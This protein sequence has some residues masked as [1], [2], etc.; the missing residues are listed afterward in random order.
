MPC[1]GTHLIGIVSAVV[2]AVAEELVVDA[3][4]VG[5]VVGAAGAGRDDAHEG[6]ER[7]A[8]RQLPL[9]VVRGLSLK[10]GLK[11]GANAVAVGDVGLRHGPVTEVLRDLERK[12]L[13]D[14]KLGRG[15]NGIAEVR[16]YFI[17][18]SMIGLCHPCQ[19]K[20]NIMKYKPLCLNYI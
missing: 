5:A 1:L 6:H 10:V 14:L 17:V 18:V 3:L 12:G 20:T 11:D 19:Y 2:V 7:L 8:G 13:I 9:L 4:A 16:S 15:L